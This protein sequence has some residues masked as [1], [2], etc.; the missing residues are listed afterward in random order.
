MD[1]IT[2]R[3]A[4]KYIAALLLV[5]WTSA[6]AGHTN[7]ERAN[8]ALM[9]QYLGQE[10]ERSGLVASEGIVN[11][12]EAIEA[13]GSRGF[14]DIGYG[15]GREASA[16]LQADRRLVSLFEKRK[17]KAAKGDIV[18]QLRLGL[19]YANGEGTPQNHPEAVK[20]LRNP[21]EQGH[22]EAQFALAELYVSGKGVIRNPEEAA[23]W[24]L[25][26][27]EQGHEAAQHKLGVMYAEGLGIRYDPIT[28]E[29]W[30]IKAAERGNANMQFNLAERYANG[31]GVRFDPGKAEMWYRSAAMHGNP[32]MQFYLGRLYRE[33][34][35][36]VRRD[37]DEAMVWLTK[38]A[39]NGHAASKLSL[40]VM[41]F[42][43][44][45]I[46]VDMVQAHKW[47]TLA[48]ASGPEKWRSS[49]IIYIAEDKEFMEKLKN[50]ANNYLKLAEER[51][52]K[53]Q[54]MLARNLAADWQKKHR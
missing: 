25:K 52:N 24:Y 23:V 47:F 27:A 39:E 36:L 9:R 19:M 10:A 53:E 45:G 3:A 33:Q 2:K 43:G 5:S 22:I 29:K 41:Y 42:N 32:D 14:E 51:M 34:G 7:I 1:N 4:L 6:E 46:Q 48:A 12:D 37:P 18:S 35:Y 11:R 44:D 15:M 31:Q 40:G 49:K 8:D 50:E 13:G 54:I 26:A 17:L 30:L 16:S 28:A 21:A 20:W 38:A